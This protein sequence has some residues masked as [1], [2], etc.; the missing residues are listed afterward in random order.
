[1]NDSNAHWFILLIFSICFIQWFLIIDW[2]GQSESHSAIDFLLSFV[3][4][5]SLLFGCYSSDGSI[6]IVPHI[7][8]SISFQLRIFR[9]VAIQSTLL[10]CFDGACRC[11][12]AYGSVAGLRESERSCCV[13]RYT[14]CADNHCPSVSVSISMVLSFISLFDNSNYS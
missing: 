1:M 13:Y 2:V 10:G 14:H 11:C 7:F 9:F 3:F 6:Q 5:G 12:D 4:F 8:Q